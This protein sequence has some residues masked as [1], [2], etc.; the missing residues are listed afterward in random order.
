MTAQITVS[1]DL[2]LNAGSATLIEDV[3]V[4]MTICGENDGCGGLNWW[5]S[6]LK[7]EFVGEDLIITDSEAGSRNGYRSSCLDHLVMRQLYETAEK[8][9]VVHSEV[10]DQLVPLVLGRVA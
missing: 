6:E 7:A 3:P 8:D 1:T 10:A 9:D 2:P 4:E 5:I